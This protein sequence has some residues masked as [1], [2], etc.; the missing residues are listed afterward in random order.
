MQY[1]FVRKIQDHKILKLNMINGINCYDYDKIHELD[2]V[3]PTY[4]FPNEELIASDLRQLVFDNEILFDKRKLVESLIENAKR[5]DGVIYNEKIEDNVFKYSVVLTNLALNVEFIFNPDSG[6]IH[7]TSLV[8][9]F[10]NLVVNYNATKTCY[11]EGNKRFE[12]YEV[13]DSTKTEIME[14]SKSKKYKFIY[15]VLYNLRKHDIRGDEYKERCRLNRI[16][17]ARNHA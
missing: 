16:K 3:F 6:G 10:D 11:N 13:D 12:F 7:Y 15:D 8:F 5:I 17:S 14:R 4:E 2:D 1:I 9:M